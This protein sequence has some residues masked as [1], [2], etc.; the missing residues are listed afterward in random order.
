VTG[1]ACWRAEFACW[2]IFLYGWISG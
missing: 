1:W 2:V